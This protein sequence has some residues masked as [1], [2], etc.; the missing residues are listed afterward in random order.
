MTEG[1][2]TETYITEWKDKDNVIISLWHCEDF[3]NDIPEQ[4]G[5][6]ELAVYKHGEH[7][8]EALV[9][10]LYVDEPH[11]R[12][13]LARELM[14]EAHKTAKHLGAKVTALEWSLKESPQWVFDWYTRL[15]YDEKE[16]GNGCA[17]MKRPLTN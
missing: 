9:W 11:R 12:K 17:L 3:D 7:E 14:D 6:V 1:Y 13:G 5:V 2:Y 4:V 16:I 8:G 10:N 15:G